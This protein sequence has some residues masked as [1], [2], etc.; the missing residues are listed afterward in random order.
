[1]MIEHDGRRDRGRCAK[2]VRLPHGIKVAG[3]AAILLLVCAVM[4]DPVWAT[5]DD[6]AL[7]MVGSGFG[8][9]NAPASQLVFAHPVYG[10]ALNALTPLLGTSA[11][12]WLT[13]AGL[14]LVAGTLGVTLGPMRFG[15]PALAV[16][17]LALLLPATLSPQFT[18]TSALL[19]AAGA[20]WFLAEEK[21]H[22]GNIMAVLALVFA[23][24]LRS[25]S[26]EMGLLLLVPVLALHRPWRSGRVRQFL[27]ISIAI[28][29]VGTATD[30]LW[31]HFQPGW[32]QALE[33]NRLR[34]V[35]TDFH[36]VPW[37][38]E[39]PAYKA[40]G[41]TSLD[42]GM[43]M[44]WYPY[45][46]IFAPDRLSMLI[47]AVG[48]PPLSPP[49][50]AWASWFSMPWGWTTLTLALAAVGALGLAIRPRRFVFAWAVAPL[51]C[52][53][54]LGWSGRQPLE[55]VWFA[56]VCTVGCTAACLA[57]RQSAST[58]QRVAI[59]VALLLAA[60][61]AGQAISAHETVVSNAKAYRGWLE[62]HPIQS[63]KPVVVWGAFLKYEWIVPVLTPHNPFPP[64]GIVGIGALSDSP[65]QRAVL[66]RLHITDVSAWLC[67]GPGTTLIA[68]ELQVGLL[69]RFCE[70]QM[71]V[72][73]NAQLVAELGDTQ[74]YEL[75][76]AKKP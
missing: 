63:G 10:L 16:C 12:G 5:N 7:A 56:L 11:H 23:F 13:V 68:E 21:G 24:A 40:A 69:K 18:I 51:A 38:P 55:R 22:A 2:S 31:L 14:M 35:F 75:S 17:W 1:M 50:G 39:N 64:E 45:G 48:L 72:T 6:V 60:A 71:G 65:V 47:R 76:P 74:V 42:Y 29:A 3:V 20:A 73:P 44:N 26:F 33:A 53:Y 25:Q 61:G 4:L 70:E 9:A 58:A 37:V 34:A 15:I 41:W 49:P 46:A 28:I 59:I 54:L 67:Q 19:F 62:T 30:W 32:Q 52:L 43:F 36:R 57:L 8:I 66:A 27:L